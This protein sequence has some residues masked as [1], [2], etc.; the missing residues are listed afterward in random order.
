MFQYSI[1]VTLVLVPIQN[2]IHWS[3]FLKG[4]DRLDWK[5]EASAHM[6]M[7]YVLALRAPVKQVMTNC[8]S[9][10]IHP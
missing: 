8:K 4:G 2:P 3:L 5:L 1:S 6:S 7:G 10:I 9:G